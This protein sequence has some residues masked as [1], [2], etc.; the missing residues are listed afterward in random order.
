MNRR[1]LGKGLDALLGHADG[2]AE[3]GSIDRSELIRIGLERIGPN[4]YQPRR[5]F[6]EEELRALADSIREHGVLQPILVRPDPDD[7]ERYQLIAGERRLRACVL[8]QVFEVPARIMALD[9][10][11]VAELALV[12]NLQRE[13]LGPLEKAVAFRDY[14]A[15]HG[16]TQEELA[17]RLGLD[18]STVANLIRLLDLPDSVAEW[19]RQ[20]KLTQGHARALL[21]LGDA[22]AIIAAAA[23]V[24]E[25]GLSVRQTETLV[26]GG[27][28]Y[29]ARATSGSS[30][31]SRRSNDP[32]ER[33]VP[34][35][36]R[37][38]E[39]HLRQ[40][41]G[42]AVAVK[43]TGQGKGRIVIEFANEEEFA[44][45]SALIRDF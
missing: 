19:L 15:A 34:S 7:P 10:R 3:P 17:K 20:R 25:E 44:R 31:A 6:P 9:D 45:V 28:P 1:R 18:R 11:K 41:F 8:A 14:L 32:A 4:P 26:S 42:T 27:D 43:P 2:G 22:E 33:V 16:C 23:R 35:H 37:D 40:K 21:A 30:S 13:D 39:T 36:F 38:L 24:V 5:D 12:E 29:A